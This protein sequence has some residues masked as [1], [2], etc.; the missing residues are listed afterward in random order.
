MTITRPVSTT[1]LLSA[2]FGV[3]SVVA[4]AKALNVSALAVLVATTAGTAWFFFGLL[5]ESFFG[6]AVTMTDWSRAQKGRSLKLDA[7]YKSA[8]YR[9]LTFLSFLVFVALVASLERKDYTSTA[10][11]LGLECGFILTHLAVL[12]S[13]PNG[14]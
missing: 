2:L 7:A 12:R 13:V 6:L 11:A 3:V 1:H 4:I 8:S 5:P 14:A 10:I 9:A